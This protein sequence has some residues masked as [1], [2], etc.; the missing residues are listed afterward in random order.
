[1]FA[2]STE[3]HIDVATIDDVPRLAELLGI[4][5]E[6]EEEFTPDRAAQERGLRRIIA[7]AGLGRVLVVRDETRVIGMVSLLFSVSTA[8]G[9]TVATLEDMVVAPERRAEGGGSALLTAA[10]EHARQAGCRRITLL[11]D[12]SNASARRFYGRHGFQLS[13]MV[14]MRLL[15]DGQF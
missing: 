13:K 1:L 9:D 11:T 14:P 5:F 4:L 7:D 3:M 8:L 2:D 6:Q 15:L 12:G 10:I